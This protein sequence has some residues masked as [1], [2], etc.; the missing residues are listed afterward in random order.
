M[1]IKNGKF[2][3]A[4]DELSRALSDE[5]LLGR[6]AP[7][8]HL[9][10]AKLAERFSV[11]RT[12]VREALRQIVASGLVER[13]PHLGVYVTALPA[14]KLA[15]MFELAADLEGLCARYAAVR[16]SAE[17]K[18]EIQQLHEES[19][20]F[21]EQDDPDSYD[22]MNLSFHGKIFTG[23][24]NTYLA[25]TAFVAR[26]RILP[27]RRA[28]FRLQKRMTLSHSEHGAILE[29]IVAEE[30][31]RAELLMRKHVNGSYSASQ[32]LLNQLF[33]GAGQE[34]V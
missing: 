20:K 3:H 31:Q 11:S 29:A 21:V 27:Y 16:M 6:I 1:T 30:S 14:C 23:C 26:S 13:R 7:G 32:K 28:Q 10:E 8:T 24:H 22:E 4:A 15:E 34:S 17:E 19:G 9:N 25:E 18:K 33:S 5:I 2:G 12:P